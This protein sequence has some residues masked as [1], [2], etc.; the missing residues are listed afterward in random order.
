MEQQRR[1]FLILLGTTGIG[2]LAGCASSDDESTDTATGTPAKST[3]T[4]ETDTPTPTDATTPQ[5]TKEVAKIAAEE[6]DS[7][8]DFGRSVAISDDG[9]TA[10]V[11]A[12]GSAYVFNRTEGTWSR[13]GRLT[14]E[15][16]SSG[17]FGYSVAV[18]EDGTTA[19]IGAQQAS[20]P[21]A[22]NAGA[23]YVFSRSNGSWSQQAKLAADDRSRF[24]G[25]GFSVAISDNGATALITAQQDANPNGEGTG[26]VYVFS[27]SGDSWSLQT[28]LTPEESVSGEVFGAS[29][30]ILDDGSTALIGRFG[31]SGSPDDPIGSVQVFDR[32]DGGWTRQATL[33]PDDGVKNK[34]FGYSVSAADG[35]PTAVVGAQNDQSAYVF[36][37]STGS[38]G[39]QAKLTGDGDDEFGLATAVSN[40]GTTVVIGAQIDEHSNGQRVGSA[41]EFSRSGRDWTQQTR[42][43]PEDGDANDQ[44]GSSAA[45]SGDGSIGL[46]GARNDADPNGSDA[47]AAYI[48]E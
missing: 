7:N 13:A 32:G 5:L 45:V 8:E 17:R 1:R 10:V 22:Y 21:N 34:G 46:I 35:G 41:F 38:W 47:G 27:Q 31:Y 37:R 25:F 30:G 6:G 2:S 26:S 14:P 18:S 20:F 36:S 40:D 16:G 19:L 43:S 15:D 28:K 39:Q 29:I 12:T 33:R 48:F 24:D 23:A 4:R 11:G 42:L 9:T 44:F 3:P